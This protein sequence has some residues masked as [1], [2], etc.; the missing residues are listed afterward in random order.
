L[1][2]A[3]ATLPEHDEANED[4]TINGGG[5][6]Q[7]IGPYHS[8]VLVEIFQPISATVR[9]AWVTRPETAMDLVLPDKTVEHH[10]G[11]SILFTLDNGEVLPSSF[12]LASCCHSERVA[13]TEI[14]GT[15]GTVSFD[16]TKR[17]KLNLGFDDGGK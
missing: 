16:L 10:V 3:T 8:A 17:T 2:A 6:L 13:L 14:E 4:L 15:R 11:A 7:D 1:A 9:H 5:V 12:E